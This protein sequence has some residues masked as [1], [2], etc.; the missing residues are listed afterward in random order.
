MEKLAT[1]D[2]YTISRSSSAYGRLRGDLMRG[3]IAGLALCTASVGVTTPAQ[4]D[5]SF[6]LFPFLAQYIPAFVYDFSRFHIV[7]ADD[8]AYVTSPSGTYHLGQSASLLGGAQNAA[9]ILGSVMLLNY[10]RQQGTGS[11]AL[12]GVNA[13]FGDDGQTKLAMSSL[14]SDTIWWMDTSASHVDESIT[15]QALNGTFAAV[16]GGFVQPLA[17]NLSIGFGGGYLRGDL[18]AS[19]GQ[20]IALN[21][22]QLGGEISYAYAPTGRLF[23]NGGYNREFRHNAWF[24][25]TDDYA[26]DRFTLDLGIH[27][28]FPF[29]DGW[30]FDT[31]LDWRQTLSNR[32]SSTD[33]NG[34]TYAADSSSFGRAALTGRVSKSIGS[35]ELF[36]QA[37]LGFV[38]NDSSALNLAAD[39][40]TGSV[41]A[42]ATFAVSDNAVL[43]IEGFASVGRSD[44]TAFG[45]KLHFGT[46]W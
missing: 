8:G 22:L 13:Y 12:T 41:G 3:A 34:T 43:G 31:T 28:T 21:G 26:V 33:S 36:A 14:P 4:A 24:A 5:Q 38:T 9:F 29:A 2:R 16:R 44:V 45:G 30:A 27:H 42:G 40:W 35:G 17:D 10:Q 1:R 6:L 25:G 15:G 37:S 32:N 11:A 7:I 18:N 19:G 23:L 46:A 20:T 39:P